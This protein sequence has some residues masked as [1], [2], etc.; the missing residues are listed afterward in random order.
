MKKLMLLLLLASV[1]CGCD[2][3]DVDQGETYK[4]WPNGKIAFH[5]S[6]DFSTTDIE[7]I[8]EAMDAW[9]ASTDIEFVEMDVTGDYIC[10][11][12]LKNESC[13]K[14]GHNKNSFVYLQE[15]LSLYA[16]MHELGHVICLPDE[17]RRKDRNSNITIQWDNIKEGEEHNF[18]IDYK[19]P[20]WYYDFE[21]DLRSIM[22]YN[23]F[24]FLKDRGFVFTVNDDPDMWIFNPEI[25]TKDIEKVN[26]IYE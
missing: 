5:I 21:Y 2:Y 13:A 16:A 15:N 18:Y 7:N 12:Q 26:A 6:K 25:T 23:S 9:E 22:H 17:V 19:I 20:S 10:Y 4:K 1:L 14:I 8:Y 24:T 11:I 3:C